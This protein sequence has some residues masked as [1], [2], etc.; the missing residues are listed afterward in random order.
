MSIN[1]QKKFANNFQLRAQASVLK[2]AVLDEQSKNTNLRESLRS[3]ETHLRRSE[4]EVDSLGF[5]NKQLEQRVATLQEDLTEISKKNTK[6]VKN[7]TKTGA[8]DDKLAASR[9]LNAENNFEN[10]SVILGEE[11]QKK[12]FENAQLASMVADKS[13]E[14]ELQASRIDELEQ[15]VTKLSVEQAAMEGKL[16]K[17]IDRLLAKNR[18]LEAKVVDAGSIVGSDDTLYV[19]EGD[20]PSLTVHQTTPTQED[21]IAALEKESVYW[22]T[23]CEILKINAKTHEGKE[24]IRS[25]GDIK[26]VTEIDPKSDPSALTPEQLLGNHFSKKIEELFMAKCM[27]DSKLTIH[28]EEVS[29]WMTP[30]LWE[31]SQ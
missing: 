3:R 10:D 24:T 18:D 9:A 6:N 4:Q 8:L 11:L 12:I 28:L 17:E 22:R 15:T 1:L 25:T 30:S 2:R 27:A 19:S 20:Q 31:A 29:S 13:S 23:Q 26:S 16:R 7:K 5:R 21:R 14:V